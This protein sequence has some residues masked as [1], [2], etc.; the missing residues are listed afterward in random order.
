M[1]I[2]CTALPTLTELR[3]ERR[4]SQRELAL[5]VSALKPEA[6]MSSKLLTKIES[7][8]RTC[9]LLQAQVIARILSV[10]ASN[11]FGVFDE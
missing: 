9:S 11:I 2:R 5:M 4:W 1:D 6:A 3:N 10:P 7:G 8:D